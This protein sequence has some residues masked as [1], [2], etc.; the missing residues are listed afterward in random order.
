VEAL[1]KMFHLSVEEARVVGE[2]TGRVEEKMD[3]VTQRLA[4]LEES[5]RLPTVNFNP[6][7]PD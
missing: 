3:N 7:K 5:L 2:N 6:S 4:G 1:Q